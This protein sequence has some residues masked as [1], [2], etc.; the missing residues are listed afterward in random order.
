LLSR[1]QLEEVLALLD[2]SDARSIDFVAPR[3][4]SFLDNSRTQPGTPA[5]VSLLLSGLL[6]EEYD[7]LVLGAVDLP[8]HIPSGLTIGAITRRLTPYDA[9]ISNEDLILD[10]LPDGAAVVANSYRREA[11][12][13]CYRKDLRIVQ[14]RG[15]LDS[16]IQKVQT[17]KIDAAV[18]AAADMERLNRHDYVV[19][20]LTNSVCIPAAGQGA[21]ALLIRSSDE[22]FRDCLQSINDHTTYSCLRAEW[23]FLEHLGVDNTSVA[24]V[25]GSIERKALELEGVLPIPDVTEKIHFM[26]KGHLGQEEELGQTL[27]KEILESGGHEA[28]EQINLL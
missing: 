5:R 14:A 12:M 10:E 19:E 24:G 17:G 4:T 20:L 23:S 28:L 21:L 22:S 27:A 1:V 11:Q 13:L 16:L 2:N 3:A 8:T 25:V 7:A 15:S 9:L 26:V 6:T 18:V